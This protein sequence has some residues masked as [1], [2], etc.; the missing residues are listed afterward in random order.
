MHLYSCYIVASVTFCPYIGG[1][2]MAAGN[3]LQSTWRTSTEQKKAPHTQR[4]LAAGALAV[5]FPATFIYLYPSVFCHNIFLHYHQ[6]LAMK[7]H[8]MS[9]GCRCMYKINIHTAK[10]LHHFVIIIYLHTIYT[11]T[12]RSESHSISVSSLV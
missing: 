6:H 2:W 9:R 10:R 7:S 1:L 11:R 4:Q 12:S 3:I 5:M 8:R